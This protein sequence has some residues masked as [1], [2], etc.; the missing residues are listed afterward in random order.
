MADQQDR[1]D[2]TPEDS[3][4]SADPATSNPGPDPATPPPSK[5]IP[6]KAAKK[7]PTK[8]AKK[9]PAKK[10]PAKKAAV[11]AKKAP[12]KKAPPKAEPPAIPAALVDAIAGGDLNEAAK[13]AAAQAKSTV[14]AAPNPVSGPIPVPYVGPEHS[15]LPMAAAVTAGVLALLMV[16]ILRRRS[17]D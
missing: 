14:A 16:L 17:D 11:A 1:P 5:K 15:R 6:A 4:P 3:T 8:A 7:G 9:A 2:A 13:A 12:P 10:V